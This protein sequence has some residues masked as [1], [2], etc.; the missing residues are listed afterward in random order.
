MGADP[1]QAKVVWTR[2]EAHL[3]SIRDRLPESARA[4]A[5]APWH[6]DPNDHRCPHD[7]WTE[8]LLVAERAWGD[9]RQRRRI[10][11]EVRLLGAWH[12]GHLTLRYRNVVAYRLDQP[13][14][15]ADRLYR[16]WVGHGDWL[17][18]DVGLSA[19]GFVTHEVLVAWGGRW[20]IE[21]EDLADSW[22]RGEYASETLD[23]DEDSPN[24]L[25]HPPESAT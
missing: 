19:E 4:F 11:I 7:T 5:E 1:A 22:E 24:R 8:R 9:R 18:D 17:V 21:C 15:P 23:V 13:N 2:H 3:R 25:G 6:Y 14:R 16:R 20:Y 10:D 12:D